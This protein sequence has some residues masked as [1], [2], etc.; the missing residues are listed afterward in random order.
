MSGSPVGNTVAEPLAVIPAA[1]YADLRGTT[2]SRWIRIPG[3]G[4]EESAMTLQ[5]FESRPVTDVAAAPAIAY[6]FRSDAPVVS[7]EVRFLPTHRIHEGLG[8]RYAI[9]VDGGAEQIMDI[10]S[11]ANAS[12]DWSHN[13]LCGYSRRTSKH[14]LNGTGK[15]TVT[16]RLLDPGMVLSQVRVF[17]DE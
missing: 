12:P 1:D 4:I 14:V 3:L 11:E 7:V 15:H 16:I 2:E 6:A 5:P 8:L 9:G 17:A 13:V 10:N